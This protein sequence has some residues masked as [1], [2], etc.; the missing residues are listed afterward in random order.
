MTPM[1]YLD[2]EHPIRLAHRGSRILWPE[3]TMAAFQ[4][5]VELGYRYIETDVRMTADRRVVVFHDE[6]L[7]R[8]TNG[9]GRIADWRWDDLR[10]LDAAFHH[11]PD[12][13]HP[14][15]GRGQRIPLLA[16]VFEAF[17]DI[18]FNLD[19][20]ASGIEWAVWEEIARHER[21]D[22]TLIGSF[23]DSRIRRFRRVSRGAVA[24]SAGP[25]AVLRMKTA[26]RLGRTVSTPYAAFQVPTSMSEVT[27]VD[28]RFVA[29]CH[30]S[31]AQVHCWTINEKSEMQR[32][33]E[34][35]VDGIVT[36]RPDVLNQVVGV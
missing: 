30:D 20:K 4:G 21:T 18:R 7:D 8:L 2:A 19:L 22:S 14:W 23:F 26:A 16:E 15:R 5:A 34:L 3:N 31:G 32:L 1:A 24:V 25:A 13:G 12:Q 11:D 33:L 36:D 28:S 35:G 6:D 9:T 10:H 29:A 27:V 17:P